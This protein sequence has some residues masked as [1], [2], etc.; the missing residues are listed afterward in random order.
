M[1]R[2]KIIA[3]A[4]TEL[5]GALLC[6]T[7]N[8]NETTS[9]AAYRRRED[10]LGWLYKA[11][12][13]LF[14]WQDDHCKQASVQEIEKCRALIEA[15]GGEVVET[16][17][18]DPVAVEVIR[19]PEP[20]QEKKPWAWTEKEYSEYISGPDDWEEKK[21]FYSDIKQWGFDPQGV[22]MSMPEYRHWARKAKEDATEWVAG[23]D[24]P[25]A[26]PDHGM[27]R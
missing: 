22:Q 5:L 21:R 16:I 19:S 2:L 15:Y 8:S 24:T 17:K 10:G 7:L 4:L 11:I 6:L 12:N 14:F 13:T 27:Q 23:Y 20:E 3:D 25:E 1:K 18:T 26:A 9:G